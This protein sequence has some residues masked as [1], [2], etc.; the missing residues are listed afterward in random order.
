MKWKR[1][2]GIRNN[3]ILWLTQ[4]SWG[5]RRTNMIFSFWCEQKCSKGCHSPRQATRKRRC[6]GSIIGM[7]PCVKWRLWGRPTGEW[8]LGRWMSPSGVRSRLG[9]RLGNHNSWMVVEA[10]GWYFPG[11]VCRVSR[12]V[13][14]RQSPAGN[15]HEEVGGRNGPQRTSWK[16]K[17]D[18]RSKK[19]RKESYPGSQKWRLSK[20]GDVVYHHSILQVR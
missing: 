20:A 10:E 15:P 7:W 4:C 5:F 2:S 16:K 19:T 13:E 17:K 3:R 8:W 12:E 18:C 11:K 1:N 6:R 14:D 9:V